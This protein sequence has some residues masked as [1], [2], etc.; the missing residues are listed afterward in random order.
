MKDEE[1]IIILWLIFSVLLAAQG[2]PFHVWLVSFLGV[3]LYL[4][5]TK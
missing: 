5:L 2:A 3:K 1:I 4:W